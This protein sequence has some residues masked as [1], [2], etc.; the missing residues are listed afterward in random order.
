VEIE[1]ELFEDVQRAI[2]PESSG[3][4]PKCSSAS[5]EPTPYTFDRRIVIGRSSLPFS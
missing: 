5:G 3:S 1:E 2:E 4:I